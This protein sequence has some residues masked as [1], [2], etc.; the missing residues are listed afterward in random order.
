[1]ILLRSALMQQLISIPGITD[2]TIV[3]VRKDLLTAVPAA[4]F[5]HE[6][7]ICKTF[8]ISLEKFDISNI[9]E[10]NVDFKPL[11]LSIFHWLQRSG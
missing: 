11:T 9:Y 3:I 5:L 8:S 10:M 7:G 1:M 4:S 2:V 6:T